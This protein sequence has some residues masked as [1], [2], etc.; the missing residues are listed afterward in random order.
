[1]MTTRMSHLGRAIAVGVAV[2]WQGVALAC[3]CKV[4]PTSHLDTV[5]AARDSWADLWMQYLATGVAPPR[6]QALAQFEQLPGGHDY[7]VAYAARFEAQRAK[8][9]PKEQPP[10]A[11]RGMYEMKTVCH[12]Q[13]ANDERHTLG[14]LGAAILDFSNYWKFSHHFR[15]PTTGWRVPPGLDLA[16]DVAAFQGYLEAMAQAMKI[17]SVAKDMV[18]FHSANYVAK[19]TVDPPHGLASDTTKD[20]LYAPMLAPGG[21]R[22]YTI[23]L[24]QSKTMEKQLRVHWEAV[25][26]PILVASGLWEAH[27]NNTGEIV[28]TR[29]EIMEMSLLVAM[30]EE[31]AEGG[32]KAY[33]CE[34]MREGH[35]ILSAP[36][37]KH[38][39]KFECG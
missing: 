18:Q 20:L 36:D 1:M 38:S 23:S 16:A 31:A 34:V 28:V 39:N 2:A 30:L 11:K 3:E 35:R 8:D 25:A 9:A 26:G 22:V 6:P 7:A 10:E 5:D 13:I 33:A 24:V 4:E 15:E 14:N 27:E 12:F 32:R 29:T 19:M 21:G 17:G 37:N